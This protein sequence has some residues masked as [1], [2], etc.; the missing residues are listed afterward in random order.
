[1]RS[2]LVIENGLFK[3]SLRVWEA[4]VRFP[5][6]SNPKISNWQL[7]LLPCQMLDI[8]KG[9]FNAKN[10]LTRCYSCYNSRP[11]NFPSRAIAHKCRTKS[12]INQIFILQAF[13]RNNQPTIQPL[14]GIPLN[15]VGQ[16]TRIAQTD[17]N[18][19]NQ[20]YRCS[21]P[22]GRIHRLQGTRRVR[23]V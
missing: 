5:T 3:R 14:S 22:S 12:T 9:Q 6:W 18:A 8:Y 21:R 16:A 19:V 20:L 13:S 11:L 10:C 4:R 23:V 17:I 2:D 15:L 7:K 1:M